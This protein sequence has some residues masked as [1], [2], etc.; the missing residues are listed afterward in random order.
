MPAVRFANTSIKSITK[1]TFIFINFIIVVLHQYF[2]FYAHQYQSI[3]NHNTSIKLDT[4]NK[5]T[6]SQLYYGS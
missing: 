1:Y 2:Q 4:V 6:V 3:P 5:K